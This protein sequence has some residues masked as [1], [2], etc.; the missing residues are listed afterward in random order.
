MWTQVMEWLLSVLV[1][2]GGLEAVERG[3][4]VLLSVLESLLA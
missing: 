2:L 1:A 4:A 3:I